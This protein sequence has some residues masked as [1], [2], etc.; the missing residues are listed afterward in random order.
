MAAE[1]LSVQVAYRML[2]VSESGYYAT[3]I[4]APSE[5]SVRQAW[6]TDVIRQ[7]HLDSRGTYGS[8]RVHAE[9]MLGDCSPRDSRRASPSPP[10]R[11]AGQVEV[12][13]P[14][15]EHH[16]NDPEPWDTCSP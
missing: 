16:R 5:R 1:G 14:T 8:R 4:A 10:T 2:A 12:P 7:V 13:T 9:L 3:L 11:R 15:V 6:L